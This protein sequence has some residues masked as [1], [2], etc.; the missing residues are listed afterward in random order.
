V[1]GR[2]RLS[3]FVLAAAVALPTLARPSV[4][5]AQVGYPPSDS[6][7][8]DF[9]EKSV[10]SVVGGYLLTGKVPGNVGPSDAPLV[11]LRYDYH[12]FGPAY[13]EGRFLHGFATHDVINPDL[14]VYDRVLR[15]NAPLNFNIVDLGFVVNLTGLRTTHSL[16]P[17]ININVGTATD[18]G[19]AGD[20]SG[21][22]F[23]TNLA[24]SGGLGLRYLPYGSKFKF[25]IDVAD[26]LFDTKYPPNYRDTNGGTPVI[27]T[28][29]S[30]TAWRQ[31]VALTAGASYSFWR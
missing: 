4:A 28:T 23:G 22:S 1:I 15:Q 31:N 8:R 13:I 27:S 9:D 19:G 7:Y 2:G 18:L 29:Q 5:G 14:P 25:R 26:F 16:V 11:G 21:F 30:L 6:P 3:R 24:L 12:I 17:V 10:L 20:A